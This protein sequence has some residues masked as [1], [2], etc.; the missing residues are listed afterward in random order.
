MEGNISLNIN[1]SLLD[2]AIEY[3]R[4]SHTDLSSIVE[5]LLHDFLSERHEASRAEPLHEDLMRLA[6]SIPLTDE[7][8]L[9][10][11]RRSYLAG[12]YA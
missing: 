9:S 1:A 7:A 3:A 4:K 10:K 11:D 2:S 6:G 5:R 12:K 8:T